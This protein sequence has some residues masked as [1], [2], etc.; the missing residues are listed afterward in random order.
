MFEIDLNLKVTFVNISWD[1][2]MKSPHASVFG[3]TITT[4]VLEED[5]ALFL[6]ALAASVRQADKSS[7]FVRF[8]TAES[9]IVWTEVS[10]MHFDEGYVGTLRDITLQ[11]AAEAMRG[12]LETQLREAQKMEALGTLAGGIAHDFNNIVARILGNIEIIRSDET[13]NVASMQSLREIQIAA[14]RARDLVQQFVSF[15]GADSTN[16]ER[17][18][19]GPVV[20]EAIS[21]M[22]EKLSSELTITQKINSS[23]LTVEAN[24]AQ[25]G[26]LVLNLLSN[27]VQAIPDAPGHIEINL[28]EI[29]LEAPQLKDK[30]ALRELSQNTRAVVKLSVRDDGVG[31]D[32]VSLKKVFDPYFTTKV[33]GQGAG[34]GLAVVHGIVT[35][36]GGAIEAESEVGLGTCVTVYL[37][38]SEGA[39]PYVAPRLEARRF[40]QLERRHVVYL[41]DDE[42]LLLMVQRILER[43]GISVSCFQNPADAIA[44][45][46]QDP[47]AIDL[48]L[49]DNNM[50]EISGVEVAR[51]AIALRVDLPVAIISG[52][53][54]DQLQKEAGAAGVREVIS[55][56]NIEMLAAS[57]ERCFAA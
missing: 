5:R 10:I 39:A 49:T 26:Q 6:E 40:S 16:F 33:F 46:S 7:E 29:K 31:I 23:T 14:E 8:Q 11:R 43:R 55:K 51:K 37:P 53:V 32:S 45:I 30:L 25:I 35:T 34:L 41:D 50:P 20:E 22:R 17:I 13:S 54:D 15:S 36:H 38:A 42:N 1:R 2:L 4:Y 18:A 48:L 21:L 56:A 28:E 3:E 52:F 47:F 9:K 24:A 19:L 44:K 27:A 12:S 57:I